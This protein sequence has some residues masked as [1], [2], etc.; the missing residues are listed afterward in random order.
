MKNETNFGSE[1]VQDIRCIQ[2]GNKDVYQRKVVVNGNTQW[3]DVKTA[4]E[5]IDTHE[6]E[7]HTD[8][9]QKPASSI[10]ERF[11]GTSFKPQDL[12][13]VKTDP[14]IKKELD[15]MKAILVDKELLEN[16]MDRI[17]KMHAILI[18]IIGASP[19]TILAGNHTQI[20]KLKKNTALREA[21]LLFIDVVGDPW[22]QVKHLI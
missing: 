20:D 9:N 14:L 11:Q 6:F 22:T 7:P 15:Q 2:I 8:V 1:S 12:K 18:R 3:V 13:G 16:Y 19:E 17:I 21:V 10:S 5:E 4:V